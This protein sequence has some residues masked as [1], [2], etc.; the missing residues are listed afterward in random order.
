MHTFETE[1]ELE[2]EQNHEL[3][4]Q[5]DHPSPR[6]SRHQSPVSASSTIFVPRNTRVIRAASADIDPSVHEGCDVVL[7]DPPRAGLDSQ[8]RTVV[9]QMDQL[10]GCKR[11]NC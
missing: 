10:F 7:V 3:Q 8:T 2:K 4:P 9:A 1:G 11:G 5:L 6:F